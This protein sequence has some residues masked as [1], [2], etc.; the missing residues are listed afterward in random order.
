MEVN[1]NEEYHQENTITEEQQDE[2]AAK[3][4]LAES[5]GSFVIVSYKDHSFVGQV[6]KVIGEEV[7]ITCMQQHGVRNVFCLALC[8]RH[9]LIL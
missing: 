1:F 7:Q 3:S 9:Y 4:T 6:L 5:L 8:A 2:A